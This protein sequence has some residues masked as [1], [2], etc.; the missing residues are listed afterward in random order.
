MKESL[1]WGDLREEADE[2][3]AAL[4][5]GDSADFS[6]AMG[7]LIALFRERGGKR[8]IPISGIEIPGIKNT[9]LTIK[10]PQS[11]CAVLLRGQHLG[12]TKVLAQSGLIVNTRASDYPVPIHRPEIVHFKTALA[13]LGVGGTLRTIKDAVNGIAQNEMCQGSELACYYIRRGFYP[14][15]LTDDRFI[16][17]DFGRVQAISPQEWEDLMTFLREGY[18]SRERK[19]FKQKIVFEF[20]PQKAQ[21]L[22]AQI[23]SPILV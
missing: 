15:G 7:D 17:F 18:A 3:Y 10:P 16:N 20:L 2:V 6:G 13:G 11:D 23:T 22:Y 1:D 19:P 9:Q 12:S 4:R 5:A 8:S 21:E 14:V